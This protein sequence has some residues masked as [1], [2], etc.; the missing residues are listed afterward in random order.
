MRLRP[1]FAAM[2]L[3]AVTAG[4]FA[5]EPSP[6]KGGWLG[7]VFHPFGSSE[8]LPQYKDARL[9]GLVLA[10]QLPPGPVKLSETRQLPVNVSLT[11]RGDHAIELNFPT[12]QRIEIY[13]RDAAGG[14]VT[15]W[16]DN[17]AFEANAATVL[18]NPNEHVEYAETIATRDLTANRVFT[19]EVLVPAYPELDAR[20]KSIAAP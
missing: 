18:I 12:E 8:R 11:N 14:I 4:A 20:R 9:R 3:L 17:R 13:L 5:Q 2:I 6:P 16:S 7:R 19:V 10:V 1:V 15:R